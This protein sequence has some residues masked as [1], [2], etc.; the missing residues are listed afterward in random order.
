MIGDGEGE[1][2]VLPESTSWQP[3]R[4]VG[5]A[6]EPPGGEPGIAGD[7]RQG[8]A[9]RRSLVV[10][11]PVLVFEIGVRVRQRAC[12]RACVRL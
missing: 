6:P 7:E 4:G 10:L 11:V 8:C 12:Q 1:H 5:A 3:G 9:G 2:G